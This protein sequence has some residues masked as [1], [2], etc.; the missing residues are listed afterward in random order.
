MTSPSEA[1]VTGDSVRGE[2]FTTLGQYMLG[3]LLTNIETPDLMQRLRGQHDAWDQLAA[4]AQ[5]NP[6]DVQTLSALGTT[7]AAYLGP[8]QDEDTQAQLGVLL[9]AVAAGQGA[10][11]RVGG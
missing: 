4:A 8:D 11:L 10:A 2:I 1:S 7:L 5:Q 9:A 3:A 6:D